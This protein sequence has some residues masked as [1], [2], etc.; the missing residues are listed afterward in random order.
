MKP[1]SLVLALRSVEEFLLQRLA[2]EN[3]EILLQKVF[4][5]YIWMQTSSPDGLGTLTHFISKLRCVWPSSLSAD[6]AHAALM[7]H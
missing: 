1:I 4:V 6:A 2:A 7:V 5:M 3:H